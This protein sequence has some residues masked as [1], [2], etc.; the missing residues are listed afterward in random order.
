MTASK[1]RSSNWPTPKGKIPRA[2]VMPSG[3][4][5]PPATNRRGQRVVDVSA[6]VKQKGESK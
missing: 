4:Y 3:L 1:R 5:P 6:L 2:R